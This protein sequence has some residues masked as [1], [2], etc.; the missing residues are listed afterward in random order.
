M[1]F[2][3]SATPINTAPCFET[4]A[5]WGA[6]FVLAKNSEFGVTVGPGTDNPNV[7][8]QAFPVKGWKYFRL[9]ARARSVRHEGGK[10]KFQVNWMDGKGKFISTSQQRFDV[11]CEEETTVEWRVS[12]PEGA[13][14]GQIY[15]VPSGRN[16][17]VQ[18]LE[19]SL[20]GDAAPPAEPINEPVSRFPSNVVHLSD[21][22]NWSQFGNL[23]RGY[24]DE[25]IFKEMI[26]RVVTNTMVTYDGLV[27]LLSMIRWCETSGLQGDYVEIGSWR[28]GCAGLMAL[29]SLQYGNGKR[30]IHAF[31]SFRGLPQPIAAKDFGGELESMFDLDE[32]NSQGKLEPIGVLIA[33]ENDV[34]EL[35]LDKIGYPP[36]FF[37]IHKGWFQDTIPALR[38]S[39]DKIAILRLDGDLYESYVVALEHLFP[40]VV[41]GGFVIIDDWVL[42]GCRRAVAEYFDRNR[43]NPFLWT[44]DATT[45][46]LQRV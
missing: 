4:Q 38:E 41:K 36:E 10:G 23:F 37:S 5:G 22:T 7:F 32:S 31:D 39:I 11:V 19:M 12:A 13:I 18:Y 35:V 28:G 14:T 30:P 34:R 26:T 40:K 46:C 15:V 16:D 27:G 42:G 8:A 17:L 45:R 33:S 2:T 44:L 21:A 1:A 43:L 20:Y 9:V 29:G 3:R 24:D 6:G 25:V